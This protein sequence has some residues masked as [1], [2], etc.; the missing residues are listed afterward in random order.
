M[1]REPEAFLAS[2]THFASWDLTAAS[3]LNTQHAHFALYM[4][5]YNIN[6]AAWDA[7]SDSR[8][9]CVCTGPVKSVALLETQCSNY[10]KHRLSTFPSNF[11]PRLSIK[12]DYL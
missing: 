6:N 2:L 4:P 1:C 5:V 11:L 8:P 9:L 10:G 12:L 3:V 7:G